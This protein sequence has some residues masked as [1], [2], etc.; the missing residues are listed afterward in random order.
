MWIGT[1]AYTYN[2]FQATYR[3]KGQKIRVLHALPFSSFEGLESIQ[4]QGPLGTSRGFWPPFHEIAFTFVRLRVLWVLQ[5]SF[6]A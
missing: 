4:T 2:I 3:F 6:G 1:P 5:G